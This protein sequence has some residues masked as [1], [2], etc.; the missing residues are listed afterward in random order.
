MSKFNE[1]SR[2]NFHDF[3][4]KTKTESMCTLKD[5]WQHFQTMASTQ[6]PFDGTAHFDFLRYRPTIYHTE[7]PTG[8][9]SRAKNTLADI[10]KKIYKCVFSIYGH[11]DLRLV[12]AITDRWG[13]QS[14]YKSQPLISIAVGW[15][16][17]R[18][19]GSWGQV[20]PPNAWDPMGRTKKS[21]VSSASKLVSAPKLWLLFGKPV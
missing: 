6:W 2:L 21:A 9:T 10:K 4:Q 18:G 15:I 3:H 17:D 20:S 13:Q 19:L 11:Y 12:D 14:F 1:C 16:A 8:D 5:I 7:V